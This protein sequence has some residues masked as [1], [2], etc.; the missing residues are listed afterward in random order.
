[1]KTDLTD[2]L[3][4]L[5]IV[6]C[7]GGLLYLLNPDFQHF[8]DR[9]IQPAAKIWA[10]QHLPTWAEVKRLFMEGYK[11]GQSRIPRTDQG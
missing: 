1:V 9:D 3:C 4:T 11:D 2:M 8:V 7:S 6:L 10:Q 5:V